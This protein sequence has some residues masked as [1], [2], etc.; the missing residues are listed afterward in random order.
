M[1]GNGIFESKLRNHM[2]C[3]VSFLVMGAAA[4]WYA[5]VQAVRQLCFNERQK[6]L[7]GT[8]KGSPIL[9]GFADISRILVVMQSIWCV[10]DARLITIRLERL[11][12]AS[13]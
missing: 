4:S 7:S 9:F 3:K 2:L 12:R 1:T 8:R 11:F 5:A 13:T 10:F 6:P